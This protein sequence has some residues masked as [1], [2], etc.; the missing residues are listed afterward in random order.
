MIECNLRIL[1]AKA[2]LNIN[3]VTDM[4]NLSQPTVSKLFNNEPQ[5]VKTVKLE[6]VDRICKALS[7]Q[8][9]D[10][11]EYIPEEEA[12]LKEG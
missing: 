12:K 11:L 5:E 4:T 2:K 10:I 6:T 9:G 8:P 3:Q 7:C 1:M